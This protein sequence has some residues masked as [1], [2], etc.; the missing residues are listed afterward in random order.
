[1]DNKQQLCDAWNEKYPVGTNVLVTDDLGEKHDA[2]TTSEAEL[3]GGHTPVIW[4][5][6]RPCY[7]LSR[8][9]PAGILD[10]DND[11]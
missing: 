6:Y 8:V 3:L 5:T 10:S 1:M 11:S 9:E 7:L 2:N 4:T